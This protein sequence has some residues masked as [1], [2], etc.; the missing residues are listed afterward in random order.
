MTLTS[1]EFGLRNVLS[2]TTGMNRHKTRSYFPA[3]SRRAIYFA[4]ASAVLCCGLDISDPAIAEMTI[5]EQF[6]AA[7]RMTTE[8]DVDM[9]D[10]LTRRIPL[11]TDG[12]TARKHLE[13]N[14]FKVYE[15]EKTENSF[16][17]IAVF[18]QPR[19]L[20]GL[21]QD[22]YRVVLSVRDG[23]VT[24]VFAKIFLHAL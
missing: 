10:T 17:L 14:G 19:L 5:V 2:S 13:D 3:S 11:G 12:H 18:Y 16:L 4:L 9:T 1:R 24:S 20:G 21:V 6:Q 23:K 8:P 22:E 7:R 15:R